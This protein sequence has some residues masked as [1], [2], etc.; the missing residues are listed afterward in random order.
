MVSEGAFFIVRSVGVRRENLYGAQFQKV[1]FFLFN[2]QR[3]RLSRGNKMGFIIFT[4]V[5]IFLFRGEK[6][7]NQQ[8]KF[9]L[10]PL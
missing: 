4:D 10:Y 1:G 7:T 6:G 2:V 3:T 5:S 8:K 9:L